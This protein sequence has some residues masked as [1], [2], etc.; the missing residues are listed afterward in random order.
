[1][2]KGKPIEPK[3]IELFGF[4]SQAFALAQST[5]VSFRNPD[6]REGITLVSVHPE[7]MFVAVILR[8]LADGGRRRILKSLDPQRFFAEPVLSLSKG[9]E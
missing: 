2:R 4:S 7:T 9:S 6:D 1:M 5:E 8:S 3:L